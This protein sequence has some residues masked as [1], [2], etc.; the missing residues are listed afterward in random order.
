[1][2]DDCCIQCIRIVRVPNC[3]GAEVSS[4]RIIPV[5]KCLAF[6]YVCNVVVFFGTRF[7]FLCL[8]F[9]RNAMQTVLPFLF[10]SRRQ[11]SIISPFHK[12]IINIG[13]DMGGKSVQTN[14]FYHFL[15]LIYFSKWI[16]IRSN[17][18]TPFYIKIPSV[19]PPPTTGIRDHVPGLINQSNYRI[20]PDIS[21]H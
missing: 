16:K 8:S 9:Q 5:P 10:T 1:M 12:R 15:I 3:L 4:C 17:D 2:S 13:T 20:S 6:I 11:I 21:L 18:E 7:A 14:C 19:Y